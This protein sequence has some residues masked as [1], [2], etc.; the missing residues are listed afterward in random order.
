MSWKIYEKK[1]P[2]TKFTLFI[3][4]PDVGL[5]GPISASFLIKSLKLETLALLDSEMMP[6]LLLFHN[7]EPTFPVRIHGNDDICVLISEVAI[8]VKAMYPL[9]KMII[10]W[11]M[12]KGAEK[13]VTLSGIPVPNRL[14]LQTPRVYVTASKKEYAE[15]LA[16][17]GVQQLKE[18][19][20]SGMHALILK[21]AYIKDF[22]AIALLSESYFNYP[23][24]GAAASLIN[25][26][27]TL[28]GL[29]ID[30]TPLRE[31]EEEIRVKLRE[32]MK[33]TLETMRQA[34]K[35]YEY[36]LPAM[37]A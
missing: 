20:M 18:G 10:E 23:D 17:N 1:S 33:R 27:N 28:F 7:S 2:K 37:Y 34:G 19:F 25:A 35:E 13:I 26:I 3:G 6:P 32:L 21:E 31:Q 22:P 8:P 15:E 5:V 29:S 14:E 9:A 36:T 30:V 11:A 24:P 16:K 12:E 4:I